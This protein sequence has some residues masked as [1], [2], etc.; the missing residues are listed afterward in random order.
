[1]AE[2]AE[3]HHK[4]LDGLISAL[5]YE[6]ERQYVQRGPSDIREP[7][8]WVNFNYPVLVL[9][10]PLYAAAVEGSEIPLEEVQHV[11][12]RKY[13]PSTIAAAPSPYLID[14]IRESFLPQYL[15][16][17]DTERSNVCS[18]IEAHMT[19]LRHSINRI[20]EELQVAGPR[21]QG[22]YRDAL[23]WKPSRR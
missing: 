4:S 11:L 19:E 14:V 9:E 12:F 8:I 18:A 23:E 13:V 6:T 5:D 3:E 17:I 16:I 15:S 2:H 22:S 7:L 20:M 10:G 1:V 21:P